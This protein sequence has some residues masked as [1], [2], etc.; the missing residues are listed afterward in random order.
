MER[1]LRQADQARA[2]SASR[3]T[4]RRLVNSDPT[5]PPQ[6]EFSPGIVGCLESEFEAWLRSRPLAERA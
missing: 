4:V 6:R 1:V 3:W 5:Y 2:I